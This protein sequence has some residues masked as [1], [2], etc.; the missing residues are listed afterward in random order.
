MPIAVFYRLQLTTH[1]LLHRKMCSSSTNDTHAQYSKKNVRGEITNPANYKWIFMKIVSLSIWL[2]ANNPDD[3]CDFSYPINGALNWLFHTHS[4]RNLIEQ[5]HQQLHTQCNCKPPSKLSRFLV[6][7]NEP[8]S[9][10]INFHRF[11]S[12]DYTNKLDS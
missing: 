2:S 8:L 1:H 3:L 11:I 7:L 10:C 12:I 9:V 4:I 6:A 5:Q